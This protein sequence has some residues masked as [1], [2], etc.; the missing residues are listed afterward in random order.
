MN[1]TYPNNETITTVTPKGWL[2]PRVSWTGIIAGV[3]AGIAVYTV[4]TVLGVAI[5]LVTVAANGTDTAQGVA[6][7]T[8][9]WMAVSMGISAYVAGLTAARAAGGLTPAQGRFNGLLTGITLLTIGTWMSADLFFRGLNS[10]LNLA[11]GAVTAVTGASVAGGA[12]VANNPTGLENALNSLGL[13]DEYRVIADGLTRDE[14]SQL[15][16]DASPELTER[17]VDAAAITVESVVRNAARNI[18]NNLTEV[19]DVGGLVNRQVAAVTQALSGD[20]FVTR[21]Q[22]RGLSQAQASEVS[23]AISG[24]VEEIRTQVSQTAQAVQQRAEEVSRAAADAASK[25]AWL[26]LI[27]AG[28][29]I[30]LATVG[31]GMGNDVVPLSDLRKDK[32]NNLETR[33][34]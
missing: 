25:V 24:R 23:T 8:A 13:G 4:L 6:I 16:A 3:L 29:M 32:D 7:G 27:I 19:N 2:A 5:G 20:E 11:G 30:G 28:I 18:G 34:T 21:L 26:W 1:P 17:Q 12:A 31:G 15:I 33:R 22:R 9:I 14:L 10:A